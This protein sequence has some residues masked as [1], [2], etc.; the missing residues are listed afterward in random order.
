M[1]SALGD[2]I[3]LRNANYEKYGTTVRGTYDRVS[4]YEEYVK[5]RLSKIKELKPQTIDIMKKRLK[6]EA[7]GVITKDKVIAEKRF[8]KN[9]DKIYEAIAQMTTQGTLGQL[10]GTSA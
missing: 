1:M 5:R 2:Y 9:I 4:N 6:G 10:E 8:Q 3:H 7:D